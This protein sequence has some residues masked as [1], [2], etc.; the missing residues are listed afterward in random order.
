MSL[1]DTVPTRKQK[2]GAAIRLSSMSM[3]DWCERHGVTYQHVNRVLSGE[4][5]ASAELNAA[6]DATIDKY[7]GKAVASAAR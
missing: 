6:I 1:P 2:F 7:L 3:A 5:D 4:R